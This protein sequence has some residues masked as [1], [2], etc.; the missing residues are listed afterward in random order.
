MCHLI[1]CKS[2][3]L[4]KTIFPKENKNIQVIIFYKSYLFEIQKT[5][6][7][8]YLHNANMGGVDRCDQNLNLYRTSRVRSGIC[9]H[10]TLY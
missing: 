9:S 2:N 10:H 3:T 7:Q 5:F 8:V 6:F 4:G 1:R